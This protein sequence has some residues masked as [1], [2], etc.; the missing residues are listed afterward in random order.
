MSTPWPL[1]IHHLNYTT[2]TPIPP[3]LLTSLHLQY[4]HLPPSPFIRPLYLFACLVFFSLSSHFSSH[5]L[6][7]DPS[8]FHPFFTSLQE[9]LFSLF[10]PYFSP[11]IVWLFISIV[12]CVVLLLSSFSHSSLCLSPTL[13]PSFPDWLVF[14]TGFCCNSSFLSKFIS[15]ICIFPLCFFLSLCSIFSPS[16]SYIFSDVFGH[17]IYYFSSVLFPPFFFYV[18]LFIFHH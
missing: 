2:F 12:L 7:F 15:F 11:F 13:F 6:P 17:F 14:S 10:R 1:H 9:S 18:F 3:P 16:I 4:P 8:V 5:Y